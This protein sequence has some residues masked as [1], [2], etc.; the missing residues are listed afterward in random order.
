MMSPASIL[1]YVLRQMSVVTQ[2]CTLQKHEHGYALERRTVPDYNFIYVTRGKVVW[3]VEDVEYPLEPGQLVIVPPNVWHHAY[4]QTQRV[5]L[6]SLHCLCT[7]PGGQDVF[8]LLAPPMY[9]T[10]ET[11][12]CFDLYFRG[13]MRE[14]ERPAKPGS[15]G[16]DIRRLMFPGWAHLITRELFRD[17][18][19]RGLLKTAF[20]DPLVAA[21]LEDLNKR[22]GDPVELSDLARRSGFSAQHLNRLFRKHL[23]V[24]PLQYLA[25]IRMERAAQFLREGQLTVAEIARRVGVPDPYYFSR[26]FHQHHGASPSDF[27]KRA[28]IE[29][30]QL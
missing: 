4:C 14:F 29:A 2:L 15:D 24:T 5:T 8:Q 13:F 28:E 17:N 27:R 19:E 23:G 26:L 10:F 6:G 16:G 25:K 18:A 1:Y 12:S 3:V 7:L 30:R 22:L 9:Q 21:M 11:G 20:A